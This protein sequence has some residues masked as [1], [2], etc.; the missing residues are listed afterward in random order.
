MHHLFALFLNM[1][2]T[3]QVCGD[4]LGLGGL[5]YLE[6]TTDCADD[7]EHVCTAST[8][9]IGW[10][11]GVCCSGLGTCGYTL[12]GACAVGDTLVCGIT[13]QPEPE[14]WICNP[15]GTVDAY[16]SDDDSCQ[17]GELHVCTHGETPPAATVLTCCTTDDS[18][19]LVPG[20][21]ACEPGEWLACAHD[22]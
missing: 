2:G 5:L 3:A 4:G 6:E 7:F 13:P 20:D 16:V 12:T 18:C 9:E 15:L 1:L 14:P 11:L 17:L 21:T 8:F 22:G 10:S 19:R